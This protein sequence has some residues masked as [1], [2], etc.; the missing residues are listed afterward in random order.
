MLKEIIVARHHGFC[1][2]VERAI[3]IAED[4]AVKLGA[5][6][7]VTILK[8]IVHNEA[9]VEA[10]RS[11]GV[12]QAMSVDDVDD[13]VLIISAHGISPEV[14]CS[15]EAKG[16]EVVDATCPLVTRIYRIIRKAIDRGLHIVHY[17]DPHHDETAG[18]VGHAPDRI[19]VVAS[20]AEL[21]ALP[22]WGDRRLGLTVQTTAHAMEFEEV[23]RLARLKWP[24][25]E[26][27][28]TIC[29]ATTRRQD[30]IMELAPEVQ[31]ILVVGSQTSANSK[32]LAMI[33][34]DA[35]GHGELIGSAEDIRDEWF[36]DASGVERVGVSAGASTPQF[37]V[38]A[39]IKRLVEIGGGQVKV[40]RLRPKGRDKRLDAGLG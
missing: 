27:F 30:A 17:G 7:N 24:H 19:S 32:R 25:I 39:V 28:N 34:A 2:G 4:T 23:E 15:A 11:K 29:N 18:I 6:G 20:H 35:C 22:D 36:A 14:V 26:V 12:G 3:R 1:M 16:L 5:R 21:L 13:G 38:D 9:V 40:V 8:E 31:L 33:S 37:L 10:F